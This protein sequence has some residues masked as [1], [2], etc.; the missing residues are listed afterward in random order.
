MR[1]AHKWGQPPWR[2]T[3]DCPEAA[4]P[5]KT[6]VAVVG[7]GLTGLSAAYHL[8]RAHPDWAVTVLEAETIGAGASGRTGGIIL[9]D[10]AAGPVAEF[11]HCLDFASEVVKRERIECGWH[12]PGCWEIS[13]RKSIRNSPLEWHDEGAPLRVSRVLSGGTVDPGRL[14]AGLARAAQAEGAIIHQHRPVASLDFGPPLRLHAGGDALAA[15]WVVLATNAYRFDLSEM[16]ERGV[17]V[18]TLALATEPLEQSAIRELGL[19][20][21][22]PFY[23]QDLPYLWGRLTGQNALVLGCGLL[24]VESGDLASLSLESAEA[25][26][27]FSELERRVHGLHPALA[28]VSFSH[29]WAGPIVITEDWRPVL[30]QHSRS[31]RVL[32]AGGYS[33]HGLAQAIRMGALLAD[34]IGSIIRE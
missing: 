28:R 30:R 34:R 3:V 22:L 31:G 11:A 9:D 29:R 18:L 26:H 4:L 21:R 24:G 16:N 13:H 2:V 33:G 10:T 15:E 7:A 14:V 27:Q 5:V 19:E 23:T 1:A 20:S 25:K 32:V 17:G 12:T 6:E 8:R